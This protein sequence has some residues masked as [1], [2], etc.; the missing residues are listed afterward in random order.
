[1]SVRDNLM[2][3]LAFLAIV[4]L[5]ELPIVSA[6]IALTL[7][8][9]MFAQFWELP[10]FKSLRSIGYY[11]YYLEFSEIVVTNT[12]IGKYLRENKSAYRHDYID[13]GYTEFNTHACEL[14]KLDIRFRRLQEADDILEPYFN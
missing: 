5:P 3:I 10:F 9:F 12:E 4:L 2:N 8:Y 14:I 7:V 13:M 6:I 1:M 11:C